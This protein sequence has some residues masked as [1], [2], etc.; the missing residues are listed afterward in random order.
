MKK[1]V[2]K[3]GEVDRALRVVLR[4]LDA[5]LR[6]LNANAARHMRGGRYET[7]EQMLE[8][9]KALKG[10]RDEVTQLQAKW[11]EL[12]RGDAV[13]SA[14]TC[15][16]K[17]KKGLKKDEMTPLWEYYHP[18]LQAL[19]R[20]GGTARKHDIRRQVF[21]IMRGRLT[22]CDLSPLP[23]GRQ[24]RWE[25]RVGWCRKHLVAEGWLHAKPEKGMWK[26][27]PK[28]SEVARAA[29]QNS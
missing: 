24:K 8:I 27:T 13:G 21:E 28:G 2:P 26:L 5:S 22:P 23:S 11:R 17:G 18:I 25:S 12:K 14:T 9:G 3:A 1:H 10:Y 19:E 29:E 15:V 4:K 7:A 20:L 6:S 16:R